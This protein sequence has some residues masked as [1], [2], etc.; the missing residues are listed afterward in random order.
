MLRLLPIVLC[1]GALALAS[2]VHEVR[3]A[4]PDPKPPEET[5][6]TPDKP[7][8][9]RDLV[10]EPIGPT[11]TSAGMTAVLTDPED[12]R[13][14]WVGSLTSVWVSED[15]GATWNLVLQLSRA[16]G[17]VRENGEEPV[18]AN[19]DEPDVTPDGEDVDDIEDLQFEDEIV[20]DPRTGR[21]SRD[22]PDDPDDG[23]DGNSDD[24]TDQDDDGRAVARFGVIRMR[25]MADRVWVCTSRG[26]WS[27]ARS[28][29]RTGTGTELRFGR[30]LG[31]NDVARGAD[32]KFYM[33]TERGLWVLGDDGLGKQVRGVEEELDV[34]AI[35]V[36]KGKLVLATS[37]GL[38][39]GDGE[40]F[41]RVPLGVKDEAGL[42]DALVEPDGRVA[43]AGANNV[44]RLDQAVNVVDEVWPVPGASRLAVGREGRLWAVGPR[45]AWKFSQE[46]GWVRVV[47]GLFDRRLRDV[48]PSDAGDVHL[49]VVG[50]AGLWRLVPETSKVYESQLEAL[51]QRALKGYPSSDETVRWAT[52]ARGVKLEEVD[53]WVVEERLSWLLPRVELTL[54][55]FRQRNEDFTFIPDVD[56]RILDA[57]EVRPVDDQ[58]RIMA[59]WNVLPAMLAAIEGSNPRIEAARSR[60]RKEQERVREVV[61][62][63]WQTWAKKRMEYVSTQPESVRDAMRSLLGLARLEADLHVYTGGRFPVGGAHA[64]GAAGAD[65]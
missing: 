19:P 44:Y 3:A 18:E 57:V 53:S 29:R 1:A 27:I 14:V 21:V 28:A 6:T 25:I 41:D 13:V 11:T 61:L 32:K 34:R 55:A 62:P 40:R 33:A 37:R 15:S 22:S 49:W 8:S 23:E 65:R 30:R 24:D 51:S 48:A 16:S 45:G 46:E 7:K 50:R 38:R 2:R 54:R 58:F 10:W 42:E 60:A 56:R 20:V 26:L 52:E 64:K 4:E 5:P 39:V 59:T 63:L 31:V 12:A 35:G 36:A 9:H 17:I 43:L 47:E